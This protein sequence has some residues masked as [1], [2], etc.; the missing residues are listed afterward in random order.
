VTDEKTK[1]TKEM[2]HKLDAAL[3]HIEEIQERGRETTANIRKGLF[4]N[5][6]KDKK[7]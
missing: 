2:T 4:K 3:A 5:T 1:L 6:P 7:L